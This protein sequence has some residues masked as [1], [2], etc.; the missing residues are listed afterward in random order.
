MNGEEDFVMTMTSVVSPHSVAKLTK[1]H[2]KRII[3]VDNTDQSDD[4]HQSDVPLTE[5]HPKWIIEVDNTYQSDTNHQSCCGILADCGY[6]LY[7]YEIFQIEL[8]LN[9]DLLYFYI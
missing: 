7:K 8:S 5:T 4:N 2:P 1:T 6:S 3:E 9:R